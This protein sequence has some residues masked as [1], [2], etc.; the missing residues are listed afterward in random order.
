MLVLTGPERRQ[1]VKQVRG[2]APV[3]VEHLP[4]FRE[5]ARRISR[6]RAVAPLLR[7]FA[8][9]PVGRLLISATP[10]VI[11]MI[12]WFIAGAA[13]WALWVRFDAKRAES[14]LARHSA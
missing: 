4:V 6:Q 10:L 3:D 7:G 5:W 12:A 14:F 9:V 2:D 8:L 1:V 13:Y 11:V